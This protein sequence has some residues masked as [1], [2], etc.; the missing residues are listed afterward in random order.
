MR[1]SR[2]GVRTERVDRKQN[3]TSTQGGSAKAA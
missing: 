2:K 3:L 1:L